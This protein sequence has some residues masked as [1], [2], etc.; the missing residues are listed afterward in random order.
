MKIARSTFR[1]A[2]QRE[3]YRWCELAIL[4]A[5]N[6]NGKELGAISKPDLFAQLRV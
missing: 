2:E 1:Q 5:T 3:R 4:G 6:A